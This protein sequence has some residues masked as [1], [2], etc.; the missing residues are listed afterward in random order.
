[1]SISVIGRLEDHFVQIPNGVFRSPK[2]TSRAIHV[3][4]NILSH[5]NDFKLT[6]RFIANQ[7]GKS[8]TTVQAA[9]DDLADAGLIERKRIPGKRGQ[10]D[11]CDYIVNMWKLLDLERASSEPVS[12]TVTGPVSESGTGPV[13]EIDTAPVSESGTNRTPKKT[14]GE[15]SAGRCRSTTMSEP[16][17]DAEST[18]SKTSEELDS[19]LDALAAG[20]ASAQQ[21]TFPDHCEA[22]RHVEEP[23]AC[24]GCRRQRERRQEMLADALQKRA[25][26]S[27]NLRAGISSCEICDHL[28]YREE[29]NPRTG[30]ARSVVCSHTE[31]DAQADAQARADREALA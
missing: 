20:A 17:A 15:K 11:S 8:P 14:K 2:I 7:I 21:R 6:V 13:S 9:L 5:R 4:G 19:A 25:E 27:R 26:A 28:G 18:P 24:H 16:V 12:E 23:G 3:L 31:A 1:M 10:F 22:H 30:I 29:I